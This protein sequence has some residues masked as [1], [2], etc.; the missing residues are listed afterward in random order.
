MSEQTEGYEGK[1]L[2]KVLINRAMT[3]DAFRN[4]FLRNPEAIIEKETGK[5]LPEGIHIKAVE[6]T[7]TTVCI[8]VP[9][10]FPAEA[11]LSDEALS[12]VA[13]G[14]TTTLTTSYIRSGP[15]PFRVISGPGRV[16]DWGIGGCGSLPGSTIVNP[17]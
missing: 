15:T 5:K 14:V 12:Q 1:D 9:A 13:G 16:A 8:V 7:P 3:D 17:M 4:E 10:K 11:E 6:E 2:V